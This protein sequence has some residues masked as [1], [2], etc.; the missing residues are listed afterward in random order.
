MIAE[1]LFFYVSQKHYV[2]ETVIVT[3]MYDINHISVSGS[4]NLSI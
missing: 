3:V 4:R 1:A 2:I